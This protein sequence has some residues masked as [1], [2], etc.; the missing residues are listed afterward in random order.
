MLSTAGDPSDRGCS[1]SC[2]IIRGVESECLFFPNT[3]FVPRF[4]FFLLRQT[5]HAQNEMIEITMVAPTQGSTIPN[6]RA[7]LV[8][9]F[10]EVTF[11]TAVCVGVKIVVGRETADVLNVFEDFGVTIVEVGEK[12]AVEHHDAVERAVERDTE[13]G[14]AVPTSD[15][16]GNDQGS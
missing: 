14:G 4:G 7:V 11:A 10:S 15:G 5:I 2:T 8:V 3:F 9:G 16:R 13:L 12:C 6:K 1:V